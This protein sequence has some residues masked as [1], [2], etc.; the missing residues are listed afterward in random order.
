MRNL[1]ALIAVLLPGVALAGGY[2]VPNT[3]PRDN[4]M[5]GAN[6]A[7]EVGPEAAGNNMA[8]LAGREGFAVSA[9]GALIYLRST[10]TDTSGL[11]GGA[12]ASTLPKAA[13]P[14]NLNLS[15]GGK[16]G[17]GMGWGVGLALQAPGGGLVHWP[18]NWAGETRV[19]EVNRQIVSLDVGGA[20]QPIEQLKIGVSGVYYTASEDLFQALDFVGTKGYARVSASGSGLGYAVSAE[21]TPSKDLPLR[22]GV[23]YRHQA[24][25]KLEGDAHFEGIPAAFVTAKE[26]APLID[27]SVKH[28]LMFPNVL[29]LGVS[30]DPIKNLTI[31][32]GFTFWRWIVYKNDAFIGSKGTTI[33]VNNN[34]TN[35]QSYRLGAE[36]G[37][38]EAIP[39][40]KLRVGLVRDISPLP[41]STISPSLPDS[42]RSVFELGAGFDLTSSLQVNAS[43]EH[44]FFDEAT[45]T[46]T[47]AFPGTYNTVADI[48]MI[49]L[50]W[51]MK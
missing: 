25:I 37:G 27:Q 34:Y 20:F 26:N 49:G 41:T 7:N 29:N 24:L 43:W 17:N 31:N 23:A 16:L 51:K 9:S 2:A 45:V 1:I 32:A 44:A 12:T 35:G 36:Y 47:E 14:P 42:S 28:D 3:N 10:W 15:Y 22:F 33:L 39:A 8:A 30:Y 4:S 40:L 21:F 6:V 50:Q 38:L 48:F 19:L 46:G 18:R 11:Y 13:F 5:G